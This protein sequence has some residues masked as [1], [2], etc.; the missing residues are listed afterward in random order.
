MVEASDAGK[1][2]NPIVRKVCPNCVKKP[3]PIIQMNSFKVGVTQLIKTIG[4]RLIKETSGKY[5]IIT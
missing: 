4:K 2:F 5:P 1:F 3:I